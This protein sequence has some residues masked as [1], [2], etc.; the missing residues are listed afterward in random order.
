MV[1]HRTGESFILTK[2]AISIGS[3]NFDDEDRVKNLV[4]F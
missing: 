1:S 4:V 2:I 3:P